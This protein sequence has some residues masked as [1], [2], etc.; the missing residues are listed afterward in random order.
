MRRSEIWQIVVGAFFVVVAGGCTAW[1]WYLALHDGV[2]YPKMATLFP[3]FAVLGLGFCLFPVDVDKMRA[4]HGDPPYTI[5][6]F[7]LI[8]KIWVGVSVLSGFANF[9]V[10][11]NL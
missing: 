11:S 3:G 1:S 5:G 8:W 4:E 2:I 10:I 6:Q 7:P 9:L